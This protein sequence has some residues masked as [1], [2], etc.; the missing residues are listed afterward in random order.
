MIKVWRASRK[1]VQMLQKWTEEKILMISIFKVTTR[2]SIYMKKK[3]MPHY[4]KSKNV[5][6][7]HNSYQEV[8]TKATNI[9]QYDENQN[10]D[11]YNA[12]NFHEDTK[13]NS[14]NFHV[15]QYY[16]DELYSKLF[17]LFS[18]LVVWNWV[19]HTIL[20]KIEMM[21]QTLIY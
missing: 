14:F 9:F 1:A 10:I 11:T 15:F 18:V 4:D 21:M 16:A 17:S 12:K 2:K 3:E 6:I 13:T 20:G 5:D 7:L 19:Y 8:S